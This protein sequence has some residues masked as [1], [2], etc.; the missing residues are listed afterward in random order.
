M[1]TR[2]N[3]SPRCL[4]KIDLRKAYDSIEWEFVR[5]MLSS[6]H[7][8]PKFIA[9]VITCITSTSYFIALNGQTHGFF[10]GKRGL[11]Q[12]DPL[13]PLLFTLCMEYLSRL[14]HML[15]SLDGFKFHP[16]CKGLKLTHLMFVDDLLLF[17]KGDIPSV[18][19]LTEVF[20]CFSTTSGLHINTEKTDI[21]MNGVAP[22][23]EEV[24]L[25]HTGFK[26]G[27]LPFKY[28]GVQ[29]S[30][31]RLSNIDCN[32]LVDKM[33]A[34]IRG[35]EYGGLG[36]VDTHL[37]NLA[38]VGKLVCWIV[39]KKDHMWIKWVDKIYIKGA[40]WLDYQPSQSSSWAWRKICEIKDKF[41][42]AYDQ[43]KWLTADDM[44]TISKGYDWLNQQTQHK[45][46]WAKIVWN[47]FNTP[48]H[49]FI[50]W[51]M[52]RQRLLTLDRLQELGIATSGICFLCSRA[53]A[54]H[55]HLFQGCDY[56]KKMLSNSTFLAAG[57]YDR[58][59]FT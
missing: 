28:L 22:D 52:Q 26:K 2:K 51:L 5:Q 11:M 10:K 13:S 24:I 1:Y 54:N 45:V 20:N 55:H 8:P 6:L 32:V 53:T 40:P 16:L 58:R 36:L 29:I 25:R 27:S 44:Y 15:G 47:R 18:V 3:A 46:A 23:I 38:I 21:V 59:Y 17:C 12:G 19:A 57:H 43:G 50:H 4:M 48:R 41:R 31:K 7:F 49:C 56:A 30:H 33:L 42:D 37:W 35:K 34:K 9:W 14:I 39:V